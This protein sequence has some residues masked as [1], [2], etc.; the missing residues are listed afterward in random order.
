MVTTADLEPVSEPE[1]RMRPSEETESWKRILGEANM[2]RKDFLG[3]KMWLM[4]ESGI[5]EAGVVDSGSHSRRWVVRVSTPVL[6]RGKV[7]RSSHSR[8]T[9]ER[10]EHS[11]S[12]G[13]STGRP[14]VVSSTGGSEFPA[15][16]GWAWLVVAE[17]DCYGSS[18]SGRARSSFMA[19]SAGLTLLE[20]FYYYY[21]LGKF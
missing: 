6:R 15:I 1:P 3:E 20:K 4:A 8:S 10:R 2:E 16:E 5:A 21:L 7:G 11:I 12:L 13:R 14:L 18:G 17:D 9:E 19:D